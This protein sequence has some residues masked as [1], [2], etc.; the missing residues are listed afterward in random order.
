MRQANKKIMAVVGLTCLLVQN[1]GALAQETVPQALAAA[2]PASLSLDQLNRQ[3]LLKEIALEKFN[4]NYRLNVARQARW[5]GLRYAFFQEANNGCGIAGGIIGTIERGRHIKYSSKVRAAIQQQANFIPMIGSIVGA[6][7]AA[8]EFSIN[9]FH[10]YQAWR[11]GFSP[12]RAIAHVNSLNAEMNQL[13]AQRDALLQAE[14]YGPGTAEFLEGKVLKDLRDLS[15]M[16]YQRFHLGARRTLAFQQCQYFFDFAKNTTNALGAEFAFLALHRRDRIW[17]F[18]AGILYDI[19]GGLTVA[20][21][22]VSRG[23]AKLVSEYHRRG[24]HDTMKDVETKEI[25]LLKADQEA[26]EAVAHNKQAPVVNS[27]EPSVDRLAAYGDRAQIFQNAFDSASAEREKARLTATQNVA[28]GIYVGGSK[29]ASGTLFTILGHKRYRSK[30][31]TA[32]RVTNHLLFTSGVIGLQA[33]AVSFVD[34]LRI[35]IQGEINRRKLVKAHKL[36]NEIIKAR[37]AQL[38]DLERKLQGSTQ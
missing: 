3:I 30:T 36:P 20:G 24:L 18:R 16:E 14:G 8:L 6:S 38:D 27:L 11:K 26:L 29:I 21:P 32:G 10:E 1:N 23:Y 35:Q 17:N 4:L 31:Q 34:T 22:I 5:K 12:R 33:C 7:A 37:L 25:S 28:A 15:L 13:F 19:A 9:E 2:S